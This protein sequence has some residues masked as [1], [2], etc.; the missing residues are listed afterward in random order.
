M[1]KLR[2]LKWGTSILDYPVGLNLITRGLVSEGVESESEREEKLLVEKMEKE[3]GPRQSS[4]DSLQKRMEKAR[5]DPPQKPPARHT[6]PVR[7]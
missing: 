2:I 5:L 4:A 7:Y 3:R 1:T 6:A